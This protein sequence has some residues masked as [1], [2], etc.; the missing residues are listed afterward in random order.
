[1]N[2]FLKLIDDNHH[3][4]EGRKQKDKAARI[5]NQ[6]KEDKQRIYRQSLKNVGD[7]TSVDTTEPSP[8]TGPEDAA[9]TEPTNNQREIKIQ[10]INN[11]FKQL[12]MS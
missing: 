2:E 12:N 8:I 9:V 7:D 3:I 10:S 5:A 11:F 4:V 1:M 6:K